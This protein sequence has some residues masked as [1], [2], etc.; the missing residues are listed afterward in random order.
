MKVKYVALAAVCLMIV[1][2]ALPSEA[3]KK[4]ELAPVDPKLDDNNVFAVP[5]NS[6]ASAPAFVGPG[7]QPLS[8]TQPPRRDEF[9]YITRL[10]TLTQ[11]QTQQINRLERHFRARLDARRQTINSLQ[12]RLNETQA[13]SQIESSALADS[14]HEIDELKLQVVDEQKDAFAALYEILS[15]SQRRDY[16]AMRH[17]T[18][19]VDDATTSMPGGK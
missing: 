19:V 18:L 11:A 17:G 3:R 6:A 1:F 9:E 16:D 7:G 14:R 12:Q 10:P 15:E 5:F 8:A 13:H 4:K 2:A